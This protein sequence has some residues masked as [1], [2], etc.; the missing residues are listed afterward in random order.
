MNELREYVARQIGHLEKIIN[1]SG[2]RARLANLRR[3]VGK[4]P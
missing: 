4:V 2:G 1:T 3:G